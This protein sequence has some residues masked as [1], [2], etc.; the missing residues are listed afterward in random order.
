M[1]NWINTEIS[2]W[3][4][5]INLLFGLAVG[6][7]CWITYVKTRALIPVILAGVAGVIGIVIANNSE[8]MQQRV[9]EDLNGAPLR[10]GAAVLRARLGL[11]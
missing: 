4:V 7:I 5:T 6:V 10:L 2:Q 9:E 8:W 1:N 3:T 11:A